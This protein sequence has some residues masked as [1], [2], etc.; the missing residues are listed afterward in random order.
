MYDLKGN[1]ETGHLTAFGTFSVKE[2]RT[3]YNSFSLRLCVSQNLIYS[4]VD[5]ERFNVR[6]NN[7]LYI[8]VCTFSLEI[9]L[10]FLTKDF[11]IL[12]IT[13]Y[14]SIAKVTEK[15]SSSLSTGTKFPG[16]KKIITQSGNSLERQLSTPDET[17][18]PGLK[19][20]K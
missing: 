1:F 3:R 15:R 16:A 11:R 19:G 4:L 18:T 2:H 5:S 9:S 7:Q 10:I 12:L 8:R 17:S 6:V 20:V 14:L 13:F